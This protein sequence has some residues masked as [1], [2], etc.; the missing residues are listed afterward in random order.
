MQSLLDQ[1][2]TM[3]VVVADTGDLASIERWKPQDATTNPT[4]LAAAVQQESNKELVQRAVR[5]AQIEAGKGASKEAIVDLATD[6]LSVEFGVHIL[7]LIPGRVSTELDARLSYDQAAS[8]QKAR[9][10]IQLYKQAQVPP[11][12]VLIK[13]ASTYQ[14][15]LAA[16]TLEQEGIRCNMT[17][18][19]SLNQAAAAAAAKVTLI[20]PFVGRV[21]D[22]YKKD[23]GR[24]SYPPQEDPGVLLVTTIYNF[25]KRFDYKTEIMGASFRNI[26]E[27]IELAG[28]DLLTIA[29]PL[30]AELAGQNGTL[31]KKLSPEAAKA[32]KL[33]RLQE[34]LD[35]HFFNKRLELLPMAK[36]NLEKGIQGFTQAL[37]S[38]R[39]FLLKM[40]ISS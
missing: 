40:P 10:I 31:V 22:W 15:I 35:E 23:T 26:G 36:E 27:I 12:R 21:L 8:I 37:L 4:L 25:F 33:E 34:P 18:L 2:K 1:L 39:E 38:L 29:P 16:Q 13:L 17:L 32:I 24:D 28:C 5:K 14:G 30:L 11:E 6:H 9:R 19:F 7:S 3:T 20:S